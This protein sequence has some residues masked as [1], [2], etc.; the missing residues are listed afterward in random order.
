MIPDNASVSATYNFVPHLT[1][2]ENVYEFPVPWENVNWGVEGEDLH[3]PATV[4]WLA[5]DRSLLDTPALELLDHLL[6]REFRA[7]L[8]AL[9]VVVARRVEAPLVGSES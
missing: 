9:G 8:D 3:D 2:R 6:E 5:V 4:E 7:E 1:H